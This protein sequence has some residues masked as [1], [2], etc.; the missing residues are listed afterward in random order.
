MA[1][2]ERKIAEALLVL[3]DELSQ[4]EALAVGDLLKS[5][6]E[7]MIS[8]PP[9]KVFRHDLELRLIQ[10]LRTGKMLQSQGDLWTT[11]ATRQR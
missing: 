5:L 10:G 2:D 8:M 9:G 3:A 1:K 11:I 7:A 6:G 4:K